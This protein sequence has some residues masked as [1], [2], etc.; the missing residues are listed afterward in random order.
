[1][2]DDKVSRDKNIVAKHLYDKVL[3]IF[4]LFI[5]L[6]I[7]PLKVV[8]TLLQIMFTQLITQLFFL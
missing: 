1:M 3:N 5:L 4:L 2:P 8:F 6:F 7:C